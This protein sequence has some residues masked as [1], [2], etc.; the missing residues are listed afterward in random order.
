MLDVECAAGNMIGAREVEV[1]ETPIHDLTK[2]HRKERMWI[3]KG[4]RFY[5]KKKT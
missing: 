4:E 3:S 1:Q 2:P 5:L